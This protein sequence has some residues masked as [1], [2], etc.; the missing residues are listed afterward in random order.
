M[1]TVG[2]YYDVLAGESARFRAKFQEVLAQLQTIPGHTQSFL[3]QRVDDPDS[4]AVLSEWEDRQ[5]FLDF[6]RSDVFH[7]VTR[8]GRENVLR[9]VPR[10]TIYPSAEELGR[11]GS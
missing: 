4:Y 7:Q 5:A 6:I 8:W 2:M 3:Y 1:V 10:H 11:G 9:G